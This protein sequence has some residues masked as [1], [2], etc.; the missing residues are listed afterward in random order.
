VEGARLERSGY[1]RCSDSE[2]VRGLGKPKKNG[3]VEMAPTVS[4]CTLHK[5][6]TII[7]VDSLGRVMLHGAAP[8]SDKDCD[9]GRDYPRC[10]VPV[11]DDGHR[12][13]G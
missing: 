11:M 6:S 9:G 4:E 2:R 7:T 1:R 12:G 13:R 3:S 5:G 10:D 8:S